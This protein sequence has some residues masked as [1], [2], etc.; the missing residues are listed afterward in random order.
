MPNRKLMVVLMSFVAT[1]AVAA[2]PAWE[3]MDS[4]EG[5]DVFRR[6]IPG[7][8]VVAFR[9][10]GIVDAPIA[11]VA[12]VIL[13][14]KRATEWVDS[15]EE[16]RV[17]KMYSPT[18]FLE[19]NHIGTP[20]I[21]KDRDFLVRGKVEADLKAGTMTMSMKSVEDES[22]PPGK[23]VRGHLE[24]YWKMKSLDGGKKTHVTAEMHADPKG[25]VP[26]W[27]VNM[28]Q[29]KWPHNT[30][31]SLRKQVAKSDVKI[32]PQVAA[33][34]EPK[35]DQAITTSAAAPAKADAPKAT[36]Q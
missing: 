29:K 24:G 21:L 8:P 18:E 15:L 32:I 30:I 12:S 34:F 11:R 17:V 19:Y 14:D 25:D 28:F 2:E 27:L 3:K 33:V 1:C 5:I 35:A 20:V 23:Y 7:S 10:E 26:K 9:G 6:E 36:A 4:D 31:E 22:M 13:D 16:A